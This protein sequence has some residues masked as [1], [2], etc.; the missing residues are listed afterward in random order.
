MKRIC[1]VFLIASLAGELL[2][3]V[4]INAADRA[5]PYPIPCRV[6]DG[7]NRELFVMTLGDVQPAIADGVFDPAQDSVRLKDSTVKSN[8]YR[9]VLG[10][11]YYQ[12][13]DKSRFPLPP[14]GWC[15]WYYYYTRINDQ[16]VRRNAE[17][18]AANLKD[19][20]AVYVQ[21]DDGWQGSGARGSA[22]NWEA[23]N[24]N[25]FPNGMAALAQYIRSLGLTP[26]I[27]LAPHGQNNDS[28][29]AANPGVFMLKPDGTTASDTWEGR[30]LVDPTHPRSALY[31][32]NLFSRLVSWGYDYFKIDGQPVVVDE[33]RTKRE[34]MHNPTAAPETL[35]RRTLE[36]IRHAIGPDRY[37]LG[38]W[39]IPLEG[40][41]IMNGSRTGGDVVI[42][43]GGFMVAV[44][45]TLRHYYLHNI[46]WYTDPDVM[47]LRWP[48]TL[49]QA[50]AWAT[51]QGLTGQALLSSDRLIDLP[52][53][54]V[55]IMRRVYPA[56]DIR[57]LDLFPVEHERRVW[58]LKVNH[59][60]R[61]YDVVGVFNFGTTASDRVYL[62]WTE[63]GLPG[64]KPVHVFDFWNKE[65]LGAWAEG[66]VLD[67]P[68]TA[69]RVVTLLPCNGQIQLMST[70]R[71][72]TQGWVDLVAL[73]QD[74]PSG[75]FKGTSKVIKN[76]P[77]ELCFVFPRGT[78]YVV[79]NV[80]ARAPFGELQANVA[81]HQGW[82]VVRLTSPQTTEVSWEVQF[83][84]ADFYHFPP[85]A[86]AGL[87]I[88]RVGLD[89]VNLHW[90]EQYYLNAGYQV[91][92]GGKL[93]GY[94]PSA[95][96]P[97]R[98]LEP[99]TN[100]TVQVR[101]VWFDGTESPRAAQVSFCIAELLPRKLSLSELKPRI[102]TA[103]RDG[104]E[105]ASLPLT[106][107]A[108]L[109]GQRFDHALCV[110]TRAD[111]ELEYD[112]KALYDKF[113]AE[114]GID[115]RADENVQAEFIVL[116]DGKVLWRSGSSK[117]SDPP[118]HIEADIR[119]VHTLVLR[120][121]GV[122]G[123]QSDDRGRRRAVWAEPTLLRN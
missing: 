70:S 50:R 97:V 67:V 44:R 47:L 39:G 82:A 31:L 5:W 18:L 91:Y 78:N 24:T 92:I 114:V 121:T 86:P 46:V 4:A 52:E 15:S 110:S 26:G 69:C 105:G 25:R 56:V 85:S 14:S 19:Y 104:P 13:I 107:P 109:G 23:V 35:Y 62:R 89:G 42:G 102:V 99:R 3:V 103:G 32:S 61:Q 123:P 33:Y 55:E 83:A 116:G 7:L 80:V 30:F 54:R 76:D 45:A 68:P 29:V 9:D 16:E 12:P 119:N 112:L 60:G 77:Y 63:L 11:K 84:P 66:I 101:T 48:L 108:S 79:T 72:I 96:F 41:G 21:I 22:R 95:S 115:D 8:Y 88:E 71:H 81:N 122:A 51:L 73:S 36:T 93:L 59:L 118:K 94:T 38:C 43:W 2:H 74:G 53:E 106:M 49:D 28:V 37:L 20:G 75:T 1:N 58:D 6:R 100:Y 34:F 98:G 17:W 113:V 90:A 120:T 10:I 117:K 27:W 111:V 40:V 65:Y 64:D 57:P 87:R